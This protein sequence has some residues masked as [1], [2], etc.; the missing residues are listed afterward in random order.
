VWGAAVTADEIE[1]YAMEAAAEA[2]RKAAAQKF[3]V[4]SMARCCVGA[5][6]ETFG[7]LTVEEES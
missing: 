7:E 3:T 1:E 5:Y 6:L 2:L 4:H